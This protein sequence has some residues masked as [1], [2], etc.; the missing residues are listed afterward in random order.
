MG[1]APVYDLG[2]A[3]DYR[4]EAREKIVRA[5]NRARLERHRYVGWTVRA[6]H[7][8]LRLLSMRNLHEAVAIVRHWGAVDDATLRAAGF[9]RRRLRVVPLEGA[10]AKGDLLDDA[11]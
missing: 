3:R 1:L 11:A 10:T 7:R 9:R 2:A 5:A 6:E 8:P 4:R